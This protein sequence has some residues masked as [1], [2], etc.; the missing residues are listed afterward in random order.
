MAYDDERIA[1]ALL[2]LLEAGLADS[3]VTVQATWT[4]NGDT[5][6][7]PVPVT[8]FSGHKPT[9]LGLPSSSFPF[10]AVIAPARTPIPQPIRWGMQSSDIRVFI[11]YFVVAEDETTVNKIAHRYAE[12]IVPVL[13]AGRIVARYTQVNY[14]PEVVLSF[15]TRHTQEANAN[16][17][18][19]ADVDFIQMGRITVDFK[20]D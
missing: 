3:L 15:A 17:F 7:L 6:T 9:V 20:G 14:E 8:W 18:K 10:V 19:E 1:V 13:Q 5:V 16:A 12:A 4:A 11:E 2:A